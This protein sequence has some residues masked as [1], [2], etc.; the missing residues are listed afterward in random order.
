MR[1][2][3]RDPMEIDLHIGVA[4]QESSAVCDLPRDKARMSVDGGD[5][6][7]WLCHGGLHSCT[8]GWA[9]VG[10]ICGAMGKGAVGVRAAECGRREAGMNC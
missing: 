9:A 8:M 2:W 5:E 3:P 4:G 10:R 7:R 1:D 6:A